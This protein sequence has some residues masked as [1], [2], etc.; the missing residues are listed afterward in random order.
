MFLNS[1]FG[2][3]TQSGLQ[4]ILTKTQSGLQF[5]VFVVESWAQV[6]GKNVAPGAQTDEAQSFGP[7]LI[8]VLSMASTHVVHCDAQNAK[9]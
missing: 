6:K 3:K 2:I 7:D 1:T 5:I 4:F 9:C 8:L